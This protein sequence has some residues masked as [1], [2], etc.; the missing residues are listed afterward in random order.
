[1]E[2]SEELFA[3]SANKKAMSIW[4]TVC[5]VLSGAYLLEVVKG[6]RT[7][8]YYAAFVFICWIPV[9]VGFLV[10][11]IKG[12][13][14]GIFKE[15]IAVGYGLF[16]LFVLM[17]TTSMLPVM[18]IL[19]VASM[20]VLY[21]DRYLLM[22]CGIANILCV[23]AFIVKNYT[24]GINSP[25][26]IANY[27]IQIAAVILCYAGYI[28]SINH[29]SASDGA[30]LK[31]VEGN[32]QRVVRTIE[33]VKEASSAVVDGVTVVRE[34][35]DENKEGANTVVQSMAELAD[36]NHV[37]N[38]KV[39]SSMD[40]TEDINR[41]VA[42][43]SELTERMVALIKESSEHAS[44]SSAELENVVESTNVMAQLSAEVEKI[45][46]EFRSQFDM[47]KQETGTIESI[48]SQ[49]NLLALNASIEAARAGEAGKGFAVVAD[50]IR[51]LSMG[52]QNSSGSIMSALHHLEDTSDKMTDSI[53]TILNLI[54]ETLGKMKTVN[55]SVGAITED[56]RQLD[57]E[58]RVVD[59]AIKEVERS[60]Q[61]MV[62]NMK[63]VKDI[64][65][66]V[67]QSV[68]HSEAT[69]KTML[70]KYAETSRNV[71]LIE[72]VVG[73][74][75]EELGEGGFMG[76]SD[77]KKGM[78]LTILSPDGKEYRT[79]VEEVAKD[80]ILIRMTGEAERYFG[81]A[82]RKQ[83][84]EVQIIVDNSLYTWK[85]VGVTT[86]RTDGGSGYKL[87]TL[88]NPK[89]MNRRKYERLELNNACTVKMGSASYEGR[90]INIS[91][92]GFAFSCN[93]REFGNAKGQQVDVTVRGFEL[94]D[95]KV[96]NGCIIRSS[97][98]EDRYIIGCRMPEDHAVIRDYIKER[99][100][101]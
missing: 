71:I 62:D 77:A 57:G 33:Q 51:N 38:Q 100:S 54:G 66:M 90:M 56:S 89:V 48:T 26:D 64:M 73:R 76:V 82:D 2:Y 39:E 60:N 16:Y 35:S 5:I 55:T 44:T 18:Y 37:L 41:Q 98:D 14:T 96:L 83:D 8:A 31:S 40:M 84:Y 21:K 75:V 65:A 85:G 58:I 101:L 45:L 72:N 29:L 13:A 61:N 42:N 6:S 46:G 25:A 87:W 34:L 1:M 49:T 69:T 92:G 47:V 43:V 50:E 79:E 12:M 7:V 27:E 99:V 63:Q 95:G 81:S 70:S 67:T 10:L 3:K 28:V 91:A 52:T 97:Y 24:A 94:L 17:T 22:R 68:E 93:A 36:N 59:T 19:P 15:V 88:G 20:L 9:A 80:G 23:V 74:L 53:T 11:K 4:L 86:L 78:K 32:L 30:M